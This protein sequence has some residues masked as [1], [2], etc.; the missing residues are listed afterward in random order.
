V[1]LKTTLSAEEAAEEA[2]Q[3]DAEE[4]EGGS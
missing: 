4:E 2:A 3:V 1:P